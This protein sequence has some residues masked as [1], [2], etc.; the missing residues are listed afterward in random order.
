MMFGST[1]DSQSGSFFRKTSNILGDL[2][3]EQP[4]RKKNSST[5]DRFIPSVIQKNMFDLYQKEN[6]F[7]SS[8]FYAK[9]S[10]YYRR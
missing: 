8:I 6:K 1:N 3:I 7:D 2:D 10:T 4:L 5:D 9:K